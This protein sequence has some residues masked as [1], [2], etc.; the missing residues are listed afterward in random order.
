M[1][2]LHKGDRK[3]SRTKDFI[4]KFAATRGVIPPLKYKP[5]HIKA[6][7]ALLWGASGGKKSRIR[8]CMWKIFFVGQIW[9]HTLTSA[10]V[11][12]DAK[13]ELRASPHNTHKHRTIKIK[14]PE[15]R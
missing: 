12:G 4:N 6:W 5:C 3:Q 11:C 10:I 2:S 14:C 9:K 13:S 1:F 7:L 15:H 8:K